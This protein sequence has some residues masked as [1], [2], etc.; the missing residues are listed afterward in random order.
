MKTQLDHLVVLAHTLE[1]GV[2]WCEATLGITPGPGGEHASYGT[3]NRLFKIATPAN[4]FAYLEIIAIDPHAKGPAQGKRWFDMDDAALQAAVA[5]EPRLVHWVAN[6]SDIQ[7]ARIALKAQ[8]VDR[9]PVV[10]AKRHSRKG[11]LH[12]QITV[13]D[14]GQRLFNGALPSLIQW[15]KADEAEP[16]R[17]HPRNSLPR[18]GVSLQS[19]SITHPSADKL[20]AAYAAIGLEGVALQTGPANITAELRT[21]KGVVR[22]QSLGV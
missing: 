20:Q 10:H 17:L 11:V 16:M 5:T 12:W 1:Q 8:G 19:L 18:S 6:T 4:P 14:D 21:P 2:Q 3:H 15:G 13:R 7:A 22:L 9:G